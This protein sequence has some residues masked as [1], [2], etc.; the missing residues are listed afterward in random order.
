MM[1]VKD[2]ECASEKERKQARL[3]WAAK[4]ISQQSPS[5]YSTTSRSDRIPLQEPF[6]LV[7]QDEACQSIDPASLVPLCRAGSIT[8]VVLIGD[9]QQLKPR[10]VS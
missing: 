8:R 2:E 9:P 10:C 6:A 1:E 5:L 4:Y 3:Q 7:L